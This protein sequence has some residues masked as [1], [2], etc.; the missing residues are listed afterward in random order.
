MKNM[1]STKKG[2]GGDYK[3]CRYVP[4]VVKLTVPFCIPL[5]PPTRTCYQLHRRTPPTKQLQPSLN[6]VT[7][8]KSTDFSVELVCFS[9]FFF[10]LELAMFFSILIQARIVNIINML[11]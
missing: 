6:L 9:L 4:F 10:W 5:E 2:G 8:S 7:I 1:L 11:V 3:I